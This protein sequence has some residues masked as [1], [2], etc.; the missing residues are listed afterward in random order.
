MEEERPEVG[1]GE[2]TA[3]VA[4]GV[5]GQGLIHVLPSTQLL[6][7]LRVAPVTAKHQV[8]AALSA[9]RAATPRRTYFQGTGV[10]VSL[11]EAHA[12]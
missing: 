1:G 6:W 12:K 2:G 11:T 5:D 3:C 10:A 7:G 9:H 4:A 8:P